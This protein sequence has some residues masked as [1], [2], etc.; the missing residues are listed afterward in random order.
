MKLA[1]VYFSTEQ[2]VLDLLLDEESQDVL[3]LSNNGQVVE[4][5]QVAVVPYKDVIYT[6]LKPETV[7][8]DV[9]E[10]EAVVFAVKIDEDQEPY[11]KVE[12]NEEIAQYVF[13]EYYKMLDELSEEEE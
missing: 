5:M 11:L 13:Q 10:D 2:N 6:I 4:F 8:E 9:F 1:D 3:S 12:K 7:L